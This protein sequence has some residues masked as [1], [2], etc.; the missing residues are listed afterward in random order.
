MITVAS[1][2]RFVVE[3]S[4]HFTGEDWL[5]R[6]RGLVN[7]LKNVHEDFLYKEDVY[8]ALGMLEDMLPDDDSAIAMFKALGVKPPSKHIPT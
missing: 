7:L 5:N 2:G 1:D 8:Q 3:F 4:P 6:V